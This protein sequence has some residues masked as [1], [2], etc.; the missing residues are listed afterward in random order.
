MKV[1]FYIPNDRI[2][3]VDLSTVHM[4]NPGIGGTEYAMFALCYYLSLSIGKEMILFTNKYLKGYKAD[5]NIVYVDS[6]KDALNKAKISNVD[7]FVLHHSEHSMYRGSFNTIEG[8]N[9][10]IIVWIHNFLKPKYL[11]YYRECP[12]IKKLVFVG[13][14]FMDVY[15]DHLAY[16][17]STYIYNGI[18]IDKKI[19]LPKFEYRED[20]VIYIGNLIPGKGFHLLAKAW[21]KV[22]KEIPNAHLHV[23]GSGKLYDRSAKL[24]KYGY[25]ERRYEN[26]FMKYLIDNKGEQ[27]SSVTFHGIMGI[28]KNEIIKQCKV[29]VPNPSGFSETFGYTAVE[30]EMLGCLI[31]TIK[32]PGYIDTVTST[33]I[34]YNKSSKLSQSIIR[35][36]KKKDNNINE[37]LDFI[38]KKFDFNI[39]ACNWILLFNEILYNVDNNA[40]CDTKKICFCDWLRI[41]KSKNKHLYRFPT[42]YGTKNMIKQIINVRFYFRI[43]KKII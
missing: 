15:R 24:G 3:D 25:A 17:I 31:T 30:M 32:C 7:I 39:I 29:G 18:Y 41:I 4:A 21:K 42:L 34:L 11:T 6:L 20:N 28:E 8:T 23:I 33:G 19:N 22:I 1:A 5:I 16:N 38:Y 43:L 14:E 26:K 27:L 9:I 12:N 13:K 2:K 10:S 36:L 40:I 37:T 35:L